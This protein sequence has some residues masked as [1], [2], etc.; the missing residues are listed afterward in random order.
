MTVLESSLR[1]L[2]RE[3]ATSAALKAIE[4]LPKDPETLTGNREEIL[5]AIGEAARGEF[6]RIRSASKTIAREEAYCNGYVDLAVRI[7]HEQM[8][9]Y[10]E[11]AIKLAISAGATGDD[12]L[13]LAEKC[14]RFIVDGAMDGKKREPSG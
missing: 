1:N 6:A 4:A 10:R 13:P 8:A 14:A 2:V 3:E 11:Q 9:H 7:P 5:R 12:V